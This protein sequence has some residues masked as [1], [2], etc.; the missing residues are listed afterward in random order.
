VQENKYSARN[1]ALR[2]YLPVLGVALVLILFAAFVQWY[3]PSS[4]PRK[5]KRP[6]RAIP[7]APTPPL[8]DDDDDDNSLIG[9]YI[10]D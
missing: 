3:R 4:P 1:E 7:A 6:L 8:A 5:T 2:K 10:E 9:V